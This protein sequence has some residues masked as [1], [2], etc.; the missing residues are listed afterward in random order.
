MAKHKTRH[1]QKSKSIFEMLK[2]LLEKRGQ[3]LPMTTIVIIVIVLIVLS[4]VI[5]FFFGQ[6]TVGQKAVEE[7]QNIGQTITTTAKCNAWASGLIPSLANACDKDAAGVYSCPEESRCRAVANKIVTTCNVDKTI[8]DK[9]N[10]DIS[11]I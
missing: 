3:G 4:V 10:I 5:V 1:A 7:Q 9:Y 11:Q 6:F 2:H 8:C